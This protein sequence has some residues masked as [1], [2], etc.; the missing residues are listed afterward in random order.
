M[1]D[2]ETLEENISEGVNSALVV[3]LL[4]DIRDLILISMGLVQEVE[5]EDEDVQDDGGEE[6]A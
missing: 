4:L 2:R 6:K 1:R 5:D 3:E